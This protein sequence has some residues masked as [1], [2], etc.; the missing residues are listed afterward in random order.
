MVRKLSGYQV[1]HPEMVGWELIN[2]LIKFVLLK[3][4]S[5]NGSNDVVVATVAVTA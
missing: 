4:N 1:R 2:L 3:D 5:V